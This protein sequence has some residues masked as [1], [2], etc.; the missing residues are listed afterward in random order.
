MVFGVSEPIES[1]NPLVVFFHGFTR[2]WR[3]MGRAHSWGAALWCLVAPPEYDPA[4]PE[5]APEW[6]A[7]P[8]E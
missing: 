6:Q 7:E 1:I 2:L 3:K 5:E 8:A 4:A